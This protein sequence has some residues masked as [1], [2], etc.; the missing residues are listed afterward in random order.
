MV[1]VVHKTYPSW[2]VLI[3]SFVENKNMQKFVFVVHCNYFMIQPFS[4]LYI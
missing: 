4:C 2:V 3:A 1:N